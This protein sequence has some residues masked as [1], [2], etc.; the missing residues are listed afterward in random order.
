MIEELSIG[1][2][3]EQSSVTYL[4][5]ITIF[6]LK[7]CRVHHHAWESQ[8]KDQ[9]YLM[10]VENVLLFLAVILH[11]SDYLWERLNGKSRETS[12]LR[13]FCDEVEDLKRL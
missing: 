13:V 5:W 1:I 12:T 9:K 10:S 8:Q 3:Y 11:T 6:S 4:K 2:I 7:D